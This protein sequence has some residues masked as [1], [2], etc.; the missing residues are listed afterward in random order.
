MNPAALLGEE[1]ERDERD[2]WEN[3]RGDD[4]PVVTAR[5]PNDL[6]TDALAIAPNGRVQQERTKPAKSEPAERATEFG[7][8]CAPA[9]EAV[10][11]LTISKNCG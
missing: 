6:R 3:G 1:D 11:P 8:R 4:E 10:L 9:P 5:A 7:S 2:E